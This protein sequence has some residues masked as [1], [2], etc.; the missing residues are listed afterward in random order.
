MATE[1]SREITIYECIYKYSEEH[2]DE[3]ERVRMKENKKSYG[4]RRLYE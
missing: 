3:N 4:Q 1:R 2:A